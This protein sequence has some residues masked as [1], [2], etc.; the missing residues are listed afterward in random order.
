[1]P[2]FNDV[3][4]QMKT[5]KVNDRVALKMMYHG[6]FTTLWGTVQKLTPAPVLLTD[7]GQ[8]IVVRPIIMFNGKTYDFSS[9]SKSA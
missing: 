9:I 2:T 3:N 6:T 5:I 1:M 7:E 4:E 8:T